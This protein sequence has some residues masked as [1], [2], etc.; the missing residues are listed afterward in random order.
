M[1]L[2]LQITSKYHHWS[3]VLSGIETIWENNQ[4]SQKN[5]DHAENEKKILNQPR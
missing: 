3:N 4:N 1:F 2:K 5:F